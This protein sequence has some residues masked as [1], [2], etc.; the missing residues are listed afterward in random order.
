MVKENRENFP[1]HSP[2]ILKSYD[3][4]RHIAV[5]EAYSLLNIQQDSNLSPQKLKNAAEEGTIQ[6]YE[7]NGEQ[8]FDRLDVGRVYH[9]TPKTSDGLTIDRYFSKP[10]ENPF[11]SVGKYEK[12]NLKIAKTDGTVV[13]E[14]KDAEFPESWREDSLSIIAQKYFFK[15]DKAEWKEKL[16]QRIGREHEFSPVHLINR[17]TN[18][19]ADAGQNLGY[20]ATEEDKRAFADELKWLQ[21]NQRFAFNSPV[22]FNA[23]IFNEYKISGSQSLGYWRNPKTGEVQKNEAG[24]FVNPQCHACFIKGPNDDLE[25]ILEHVKDEGAVFSL[26]SGIG[27]E[28]GVLRAE[29]ELLSGGGKASG[30]MSFMKG[31]DFWAG[32]IK[33]GGKS[34][35]AAR[36][37][38]MR[39]HHPDIMKFIRSK[40]REEKKAKVLVEN[41]YEGG[42]DGEAITTV[43]FQNTNISV[44]LDDD[45]FKK[46]KEGGDVELF[47]VKSGKVAGKVSAE[48]LLKESAFGSWRV[49]DPNIQYE[50]SIQGMHT[51]SNSG[52]INSSNPCSEYMFL[53]DTSCNLL[54]HNLGKYADEKGKFDI[55]GFRKGVYVSSIASDI[56][57]D[58][59]SYPIKSIATISPEFRTIGVGYANLGGLLMRKG[60]AYD[61]ERGRALAAAITSLMTGT[62]YEAS[63]DMAEKLG[64][65]THFE[66]N[67]KP[68]TEVMKKHEKNL[69]KI[70]WQDVDILGLKEA[71]YNSWEKVNRRIS[72]VGIRNAQ[73]TVLAPT[74]TIAYYMGCQDSTGVEPSPSLKIFKNLAGGGSIEVV[75]EEVSNALN[76]LGYSEQQ[77]KEIMEFV[78][79]NGV[80]VG[81]PQM[82]SSHYK[83]FD[84]AFGN[85]R[86]EGTIPFEGHIRMLGATQPFISGAISKTNNLPERATVKEIYDGYILGHELGLKALAVFRNN[87]KITSALTFGDK[88]LVKLKR[89]EK[90][91]LITERGAF[92]KEVR[93]GGSSIHMIVSEYKDGRPGQIA[94]L[95][96]KSGSTLK[97]LL[98]TQGILAS[99]ALK[100]G[101]HL[102]DIIGA[103][104][105]QSFEPGGFVQGDNYIKKAGSPLDYAAKVLKLHYLGDLDAAEKREEVNIEELQGFKNGAFLHYAREGIDDWDVDHVLKDPILGGFVQADEN[106][107]KILKKKNGSQQTHNSNE[108]PC[109][110]C[111]N[112]MKQTLPGCFKCTVCGDKVGG[113]G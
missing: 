13:F 40:V 15:P 110:L 14:M 16:K 89:G 63:A 109:T 24:E 91:D 56:L 2:I 41:G 83:I 38:T 55:E 65:F 17:V 85:V 32:V 95:S 106:L 93:I 12:R 98:E 37:T 70:L 49:G 92:E 8:Y 57:N 105:S 42:M 58:S 9:Q 66:F 27:Q 23:G 35:R 87:S 50:S 77:R 104:E 29:G 30:S 59:A 22:Q 96:H 78:D 74:G 18:F 39:Y 79:K 31:Y 76:N 69:E 34:R 36:M 72:E 28:I 3:A 94:F 7:F 4:R 108:P 73:A 60:I 81:A 62:V 113:C 90:D 33:S 102:R 45:F 107:L 82:Q 46:L 1:T 68:A 103:W 101:V 111:G 43:A 20:F 99:K 47:Y 10:D 54:S 19:I 97:A 26:G 61:S 6:I 51:S 75:N 112:L 67:K 86:G 52:N 48:R 5:Q 80:V 64:T 21:I 53:D 71:A 11:E 84:T 25:S 44:R 88:S 100:R